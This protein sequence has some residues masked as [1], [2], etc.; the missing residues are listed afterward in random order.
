[1]AERAAPA[2]YIERTA[3]A[4]GDAWWIVP[5]VTVVVYVAFIGYSMLRGLDATNYEAGP[6]LSPFYSI[7]FSIVGLPFSAALYN[8]IFPL[9][10]R[11][12]CYYYRKSYYRAFFWNPPACAVV[13]RPGNYTGETRFPMAINNLHRFAFYAAVLVVIVLWYD[14]LRAF[15]HQGGFHLSLGSIWMLAN[16]VFLSLYTFSCHSFRHLI[17][18]NVDCYSCAAAGTTR[19]GWWHAI[20]GINKKHGLWAWVSLFSV[21]STDVYIRLVAAGVIRDLRLI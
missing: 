3:S 8:G 16:V 19:H 6:L 10:F 7:H 2:N 14:A 20:S 21:W 5:F 12:T 9:A 17:G 1:M 4:R 13:G 15:W 18:G 11:A